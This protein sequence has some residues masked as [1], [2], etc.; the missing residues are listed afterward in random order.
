MKPPWQRGEELAPDTGGG[1]PPAPEAASKPKN[2][3]TPKK[4]PLITGTAAPKVDDAAAN[5]TDKD[6]FVESPTRSIGRSQIK[7]KDLPDL[8]EIHATPAVAA[9]AARTS[10]T[11]P[12]LGSDPG[13]PG[14]RIA[15]AAR[16][17]AD[18]AHRSVVD[19]ENLRGPR[20]HR[21]LHLDDRRGDAL[22]PARRHGGV[23]AGQFLGQHADHRRRR[24]VGRHRAGTVFGWAFLLGVIDAILLTALA[25]VGAFIY[26]LCADFIGGVEVTLADLDQPFWWSRVGSGSL[27]LRF[28]GL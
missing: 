18:P 7:A 22:P 9:S 27:S 13:R 1:I 11:W 5:G 23:V 17:R 3:S 20:R 28:T 21:L 24:I 8:D 16:Q 10:G 14:W 6:R 19:A 2:P 15:S 25:S 12:A 4:K 26:N